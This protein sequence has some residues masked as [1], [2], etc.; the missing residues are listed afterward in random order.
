MC[1]CVCV[2]GQDLPGSWCSS[3]DQHWWPDHGSHSERSWTSSPL[4]AG[5]CSDSRLPA[6]EKGFVIVVHS[7]QRISPSIVQNQM[8]PNLPLS[9][10]P[11]FHPWTF[12]FRTRSSVTSSLQ[13]TKTSRRRLWTLSLT[14]SGW[15]LPSALQPVVSNLKSNRKKERE[16]ENKTLK[17]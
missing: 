10:V 5:R 9:A 6:D 11:S 14:A 1:V 8:Y 13:F 7:E 12:H 16:N 3:L 2:C 15:Q 4:R 17:F